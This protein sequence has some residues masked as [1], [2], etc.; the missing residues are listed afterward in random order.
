MP[1]A[2]GTELTR[3]QMK[4]RFKRLFKVPIAILSIL[5]TLKTTWHQDGLSRGQQP[6]K[7]LRKAW[8]RGRSDFIL[9]NLGPSQ[10]I[11]AHSHLIRARPII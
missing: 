5:A 10:T 7:G 4:N 1:P 11:C 3:S 6:L 2:E 9:K 8:S